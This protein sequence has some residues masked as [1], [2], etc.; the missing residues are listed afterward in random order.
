M[1]NEKECANLFQYCVEGKLPL[2]EI[3]FFLTNRCN[4][5][6]LTCWQRGDDFTI[7]E[8]LSDELWIKLLHDAITMGASHFYL[9]GGGEPMVRGDLVI[10]LAKIARQNNMFCVLHT[11]GTLF[12][13]EQMDRLIELNWDQIVFSLDGPNPE[14]NEFIRGKGT[15]DKAFRNLMYFKEHRK[16]G[17]IPIPNLGINFTITNTNYRY[18]DKIVELATEIGCGGIHATL[19]QPFNKQAE[20]FVLRTNDIEE[21]KKL[22]LQAKEIAEKEGIYHTFDSVLQSFEKQRDNEY[23]EEQNKKLD[24]VKS[25]TNS[26]VDTYCF[27]PWL[28][29]TISADGKVSPCCMFWTDNNPSIHDYSLEEIWNGDFFT[30]LRNQL[31][32]GKE[33]LPDICLNCPSQLRQ[34]SENI[35][36]ELKEKIE[37]TTKNVFVLIRRFFSRVKKEGLYS[38]LKRTKEWFFIQ[39]GKI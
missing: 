19:V 12:K 10:E 6:C 22:L 14:V 17:M 20:K 33:G 13:P 4:Q 29:M 7:T 9:V 8:E 1:A 23:I 24:T 18:V 25:E 39:L 32:S 34:R 38:T 15:F 11:N 26:F 36:N 27:E 31:Q 28:S 5:R 3:V 37:K 2:Y 30:T 35:R 16:K 21:C